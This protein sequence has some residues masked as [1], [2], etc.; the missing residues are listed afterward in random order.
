MHGF[1]GD[2]GGR[3]DIHGREFDTG[4]RVKIGKKKAAHEL[5]FV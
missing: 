3:W 2:Q 5:L 4:D 1:L